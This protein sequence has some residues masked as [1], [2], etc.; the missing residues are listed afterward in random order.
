MVAPS[1][2]KALALG[3]LVSRL[4]ERLGR[5]CSPRVRNRALEFARRRAGALDLDRCVVVHGDPHPANLLV[6]TSSRPGAESGYVFVGPDGFLADPAYDLGVVLRDCCAELLAGDGPELARR[7]VALL[8]IETGI[9]ETAIWEWGFLER[10]VTGLYTLACGVSGVA[11]PFL[12]T[13]ELLA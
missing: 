9:D 11:R 8:A 7:Y 6:L 2:E 10:V 4:W 3:Q 5:P 1:Q 13:A 12:D